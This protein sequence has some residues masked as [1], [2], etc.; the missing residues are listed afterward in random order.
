[1]VVSRQIS[2]V[3]PFGPVYAEP[4]VDAFELCNSVGKV[5]RAPPPIRCIL[6]GWFIRPPSHQASTN[7][8]NIGV[9]TRSKRSDSEEARRGHTANLAD[10]EN[11]AVAWRSFPKTHKPLKN[12]V[13]P[14]RVLN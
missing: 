1:M 5:V 7:E 8:V 2:V 4:S 6:I 14:S 13:D 11:G 12:G 3:I 9:H 10:D